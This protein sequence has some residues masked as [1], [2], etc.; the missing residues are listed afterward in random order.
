I[1]E[2]AKV[3]L[4]DIN[5][6]GAEALARELGQNAIAVTCDVTSRA[7]IDHLVQTTVS[8]FGSLDII[9]NNAGWTHDNQP[10]LEVDEATFDRVYDINVKSIFH[11]TQAALPILLQKRAGV[12]LNVG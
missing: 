12:I 1:A 9:V 8:T 6:Q 2:G 5:T 10:M 11:M 7:D 3:A 4:A